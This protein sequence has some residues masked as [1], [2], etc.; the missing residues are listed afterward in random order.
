MRRSFTRCIG[1]R[2]RAHP[3]GFRRPV[4]AA[5][6]DEDGRQLNGKLAG[7]RRIAVA[8]SAAPSRYHSA[9]GAIRRNLDRKVKTALN[10]VR[11]PACVPHLAKKS[12]LFGKLDR[13][14]SI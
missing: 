9:G 3:A 10:L 5:G 1:A 6:V 4:V 12:F 14:N 11:N 8:A 2:C 13:K 7:W